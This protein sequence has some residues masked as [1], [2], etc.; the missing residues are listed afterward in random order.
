MR[1]PITIF[2]L[3]NFRR[4]AS[5]IGLAVLLAGAYVGLRARAQSPELT[6]QA[7][8]AGK[9]AITP[10]EP[11]VLSLNR[12]LEIA[13]GR[14][15]VFI[16]LTEMTSLFAPASNSLSYAPRSLPLP[17]GENPVIIYLVSP[18][19]EWKEMARFT[20]RVSNSQPAGEAK[21]A[22]Q[23]NTAGNATQKEPNGHARRLGFD[24]FAVIPSLTLSLESQPTEAHFPASTRPERPIFNDVTLQ[25][26]LRTDVSRGPFNSQTQF[27]LVGTS[28]QGQALR[29]G[30]LGK[31]APQLDLSN[32]LIQ[33]QISKA[34]LT[35]GHVPFGTN[36]FLI[37]NFSS[38][39]ISLAMPV[40]KRL[41]FALTALNGTTIVGWD[42]FTGLDRRKHQILSGTVGYEFE[43]ERPGGLRLEVDLLHGSLLP[44]SNFNQGNITDAEQSK[45]FGFRLTTSNKSERFRAQAG[46]ARSRFN[47]P[48]DPTLD[49][50]F[51]VTRVR[52]SARNA[53]YLEASYDV[54]RNL[55]L[56]ESKKANL[57]FTFR[58]ERVDPLFRS[59][60]SY[61]L[62]NRY[63][64]QF[65]LAGSI[66]E[67]TVAFSNFRF[68]DNLDNI[69]SILKAFTR[70]NGLIL[71]APLVSLF[72]NQ[73]K[74]AWWLPRVS[75]S[76]DRIHQFADSVPSNSEI[77][78]PQIPDQ[79]STNQTFG[80]EWQAGR[81]RFGYNFNDSFQDNRSDREGVPTLST[82]GNRSHGFTLGLNPMKSLDLNFELSREN[83]TSRD[84]NANKDK[85]RTD[86]ALRYGVSINWRIMKN[87]TLA[88]SISDTLGRSLGDLSLH[89]NRRNTGYD[90]QWSYGFGWEKSGL[91]K[92]Q[93][94]FYIRYANRYARSFD[95]LFAINSLTRSQTLNVGLSFTIF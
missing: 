1:K 69:P 73:A 64:N 27:D 25:G 51:G 11:I 48:N 29:F 34:K 88:A 83:L 15:A 23:A 90:L 57:T 9:Q 47:N 68:N 56:T 44:I 89:S 49:Q 66:S 52:E 18:R 39:G 85:E 80:A 21:D 95:H 63:Q 3:Q 67:I 35:L 36:R 79:M 30:E 8:F 62:A 61:A 93:G 4:S 58:Q 78:P 37:D 24:K 81:W 5:A 6:V 45:G 43:P 2:R 91:K 55:S 53:H 7:S 38:R 54:L 12:P 71:G 13:E 33:F 86:R 17:A 16:G 65:E 31:G 28:F 42:N 46:F 60:A 94:Q 26:T 87:S 76:F 72:G 84:S 41:D 77:R 82:L 32:Y 40:N 22:S 20:L 92:L 74:P 19:D 10:L 70:R 75:Y 59:V 14:L 50:G